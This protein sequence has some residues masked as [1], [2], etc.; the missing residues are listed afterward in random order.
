MDE[1]ETNLATA[2]KS[3]APTPPIEIDPAQI[4]RGAGHGRARRLAAPLAAVLVVA[5]VAAIVVAL[6]HTGGGRSPASGSQQPVDLYGSWKLIDLQ[7]FAGAAHTVPDGD[8]TLR[9]AP[10][11]VGNCFASTR[12][13]VGAGTLQFPPEQNWV[14]RLP[15]GCPKLGA[16]QSQFIYGQVLS[17]T[18]RWTINDDQLTLSRD[19]AAALFQRVLRPAPS[20]TSSG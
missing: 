20:M 13:D 11:W 1:F 17:G 18:T 6:T 16:Q 8:L 10:G 7:G 15:T 19:G 4:T 5:A 12:V 9:V 14:S 2:L 3:A